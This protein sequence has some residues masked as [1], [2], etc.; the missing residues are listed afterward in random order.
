[1]RSPSHPSIGHQR[2]IKVITTQWK[3]HGAGEQ[4]NVEFPVK[5]KRAQHPLLIQTADRMLKTP[6]GHFNQC[7]KV[8]GA[9]DL[10]LDVSKTWVILT[11]V[12]NFKETKTLCQGEA[13]VCVSL[14]FKITRAS[15]RTACHS[16]P[17]FTFS[18][19]LSAHVDKES[20]HIAS[21]GHSWSGNTLL[22]HRSLQNVPLKP[23]KSC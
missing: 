11:R 7:L 10:E 1:M 9:P 18:L 12:K 22:H 14:V 20:V 16:F 23:G 21:A 13:E 15:K 2:L 17:L 4:W 19:L 8:R 3:I 5:G 6:I